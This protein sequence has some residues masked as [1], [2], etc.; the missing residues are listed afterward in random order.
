MGY[1]S[2][3]EGFKGGG[4]TQRL[5]PGRPVFSF[6]PEFAE[7]YEV[8]VKWAGLDNRVRLTVSLFD[9]DYKD[10]QVPAASLLGTILVNAGNAE[11]SGGELELTAAVTE[12]LT[13]ALGIGTLDSKYVTFNEIDVGGDPRGGPDFAGEP[14]SGCA[15][16]ANQCID[17]LPSPVGKR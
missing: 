12:R 8:G 9:T 4:F 3:A 16:A 17:H 10:L 5:P 11:M 13:L 14:H 1:V 15:G 6:S 7:V 2:Y